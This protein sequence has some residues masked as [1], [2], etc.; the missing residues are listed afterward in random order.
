MARRPRKIN[1][2]GTVLLVND[3][4][5]FSFALIEILRKD[6]FDVQCASSCQEAISVIKKAS[7]DLLLVDFTM[8]AK[9]GL[10]L[11]RRLRKTSGWEEKPIIVTSAR[12]APQDRDA[13]LEAGADTFLPKPFSR[14]DLRAT[15]RQYFPVPATGPLS[16]APATRA[17]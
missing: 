13:A 15:I 6:G 7:P 2:L 11:I 16:P 10:A 5:D 4:P 1:P 3:E 9:C 8:P 17:A 12:T 14:R